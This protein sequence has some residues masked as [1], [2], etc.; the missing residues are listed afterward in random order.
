MH[1]L[2]AYWFSDWLTDIIILLYSINDFYQNNI[3]GLILVIQALWT[4]ADETVFRTR[5]GRFWKN[6]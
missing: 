3:I 5:A 4:T 1:T 2:M 6:I